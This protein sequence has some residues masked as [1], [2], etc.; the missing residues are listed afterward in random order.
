LQVF[1]SPDKSPS[2]HLERAV[3]LV[4]LI[5]RGTCGF[6]RPPP[7]SAGTLSVQEK[8]EPG[9]PHV[10][11]TTLNPASNAGFGRDPW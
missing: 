10:V 11:H 6:L 5:E 3:V 1:R 8:V 4:L 2:G 9:A 7:V